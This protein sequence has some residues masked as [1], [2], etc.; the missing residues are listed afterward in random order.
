MLTSEAITPDRPREDAGPEFTR[1]LGRAQQCKREAHGVTIIAE[2]GLLAVRPA[3]EGVIRI[4]L[5]AEA[6]AE[7][8]P[9]MGTTAAVVGTL[10]GMAPAAPAPSL[11]P[12]HAGRIRPGGDGGSA[13]RLAQR[14]VL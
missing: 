6:A 7:D 4:K 2:H 14:V 3:L 12:P 10:L 5:F 1:S 8:E 13:G 11:R 9:D